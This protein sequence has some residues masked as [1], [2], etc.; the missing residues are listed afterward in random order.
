M[1]DISGATQPEPVTIT[2]EIGIPV[3]IV[4]DSNKITPRWHKEAT[5]RDEDEDP[6][7][8]P[9]TLADVILSWNMTK[10]DQPYEPTAE[11]IAVLS[12]PKQSVMLREIMK[13]AVPTSEEGN[14]SGATRSSQSSASSSTPETLQNGTQPSPSPTPS[15]SPSPT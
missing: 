1:P 14:G 3:E 2:V 12:Y 8:L 7:A 15:A 6:F 10:A 13:A 5:K 4:F 9:A 11:N